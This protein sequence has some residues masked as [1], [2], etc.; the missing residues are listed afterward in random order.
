MLNSEQPVPSFELIYQKCLVQ[1]RLHYTWSNRGSIYTWTSKRGFYYTW[2][3]KGTSII[4]GR[5]KGGFHYIWTSLTNF[6]QVPLFKL[7]RISYNAQK[8]FSLQSFQQLISMLF[9]CPMYSTSFN[10]LCISKS[11]VHLFFSDK[12]W[13]PERLEQSSTRLSIWPPL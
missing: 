8:C 5:A 10:F 3:S 6:S 4:P 13:L 7:T 11:A 12:C 9:S 1:K 2:W